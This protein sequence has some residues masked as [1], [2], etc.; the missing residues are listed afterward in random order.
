MP[1]SPAVRPLLA[2]VVPLLA[3]FSLF[4]MPVLERLGHSPEGWTDGEVS[5]VLP[6]LRPN[7][8]VGGLFLDTAG[9]HPVSGI[10]ERGGEGSRLVFDRESPRSVSALD[11][12]LVQA[13]SRCTPLVVHIRSGAV[14]VTRILRR[15][16]C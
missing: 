7:G 12:T 4:W 13:S 16:G 5:L 6:N 3:V 14:T 9:V 10:W 2:S 11:A 1:L 8:R 15:L